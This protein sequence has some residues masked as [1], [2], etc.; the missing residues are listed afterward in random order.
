MKTR[1]LLRA[2]LTVLTVASLSG[3]AFAHDRTLSYSS[4]HIS[5]QQATVTLTLNE[6]DVASLRLADG[7]RALDQYAISHL[8]LLAGG[9]P[10]AVKSRPLRLTAPEGRIRFEWNVAI[11]AGA[12]FD[13]RSDLFA[14]GASGHLHFATLH[15]NDGVTERVLTSAERLWRIESGD[16]TSVKATP[17]S[18]NDYL[19]L[20]VKHIWSGYDHLV[21]LFALLLSGGLFR[22]LVRVVTGFTIGHSIT[23]GLA[24]LDVFRPQSAPIEALI[25]L[26]IVLVAVENV[27]LLELD[28]RLLPI[29]T[30]SLLAVL[31]GW[32]CAGFGR[33][34][35]LCWL[36]MIVFLSCYYPLLHRSAATESARW[37]VA[38]IFGL[39]H[40]FGFAS[41]L[42]EAELPANKLVGALVGLNLG[43]EA[44]QI[45]LVAVVWPGLRVAL[46]RWRAVVVEVGSAFALLLGVY[47]MLGRNYL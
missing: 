17:T 22:D 7:E 28:N 29:T 41:V 9:K 2:A 24:A 35:A 26:S 36:G 3:L 30:I 18:F 20:G 42:Q 13:I 8:T 47:W 5:A 6:V 23:L 40:G 39:V 16:L 15:Q 45:A 38:L 43:I 27:W 1:F 14:E 11:P 21:F 32:S 37:I 12:P 10:C 19:L 34:P 31:G 4:W 33:I 44:G 25:G 46:T